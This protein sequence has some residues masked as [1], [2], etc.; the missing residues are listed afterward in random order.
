LLVVHKKYDAVYKGILNLVNYET[1]GYENLENGNPV[2][3]AS[4][5]EDHHIY[6]NDYL[7]K[8]WA[9]VHDTLDS[10]IAI[11]CVVNRTLIPKLSNIKVSNKAPSKYLTEIKKKNPNL[12]STLKSHMLSDELLSGEYD[13]N[14]DIFLNER[15]GLIL[16]A[17][18]KNVV[19]PK[20]DILKKY[21][22]T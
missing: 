3:M 20:A 16:A 19:E 9:S 18:T 14:Y 17:I 1:G 5:L 11:D 12:G 4:N 15:A 7:R 21:I 22:A 6:P 2:S 13:N 8:N 10:T